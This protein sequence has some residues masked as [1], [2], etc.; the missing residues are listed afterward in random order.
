MTKKDKM[1][2]NDLKILKA[3]LLM[4]DTMRIANREQLKEEILYQI[5]RIEKEN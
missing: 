2:E 4:Y 3:M 1:F 5:S